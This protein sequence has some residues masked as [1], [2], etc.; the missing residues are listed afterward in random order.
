[1][2][3]ELFSAH[4][5]RVGRHSVSESATKEPEPVLPSARS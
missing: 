1:M 4:D 2:L 3:E 5:G